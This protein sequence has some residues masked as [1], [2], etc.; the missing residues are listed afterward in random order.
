MDT[1]SQP[2]MVSNFGFSAVNVDDLGATEYTLVG[3]AC[4]VSTSVSGFRKEME[5]CLKEIVRACYSSPRADNLMLRTVFFNSRLSEFHGFKPLGNLNPDDYDGSLSPGGMT[6]LCDATVN[7]IESL[8]TYGKDLV[9]SDFDTNGIVI[10]ITD[11]M[12]NHSTNTVN[13]AKE[14]LAKITKDENLESIRTILV[15][16]V[17]DDQMIKDYLDD[18]QAE[19]GFDQ[20]VTL[21]S[22]DAKTLAKL[23]DFVS[24]SISAQSQA[25]GTGGPSQSLSF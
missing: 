11:G 24:K 13:Q 5:D 3:I 22:A 14:A 4:D 19:V 25:L 12:D 15:G 20:Y 2:L 9:E 16:V 7:I 17:Q 18:F 10:V 8:G 6:A 1:E 21:G 23:A